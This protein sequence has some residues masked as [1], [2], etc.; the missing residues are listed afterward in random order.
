MNYISTIFK[1]FHYRHIDE[2]MVTRLYALSVKS[3]TAVIV[4][5]LLFAY[6]LYPVLSNSI[7]IWE[8]V[9]IVL[10]IVR[11]YLVYVRKHDP[12]KFPLQ[13]W[14]VLFVF[15]A[16]ATATMFALVGSFGLVYLDE[17]RRIFVVATLIGLTAGAM[18]SLFPDIRIVVGYISI[19]LIPLIVSLLFVD[20]TMHIILAFLVT[21]Y[22]VTQI[23]IILNT[24][25]QNSD[26]DK[27][28]EEIH[29]EQIKLLKKEEALDYF[30]EQA[31]IGIFSYDLQLNVT[32]S[33]EAFL[34]LFGLEKVELIGN[35]LQ[36]L[37]DQRPVNALTQALISPQIYSGPYTSVK[38]LDLWVEAQCFPVHNE[39][40]DVVGGICLIENK[41]KE[42]QA[43]ED[44]QH[45][46][47]HD[48]LTS[49]L[50][51]RGLKEFVN[52]FMTKEE[53]G[54]M[55]SLLVYL[56]L[57]KFKNINDS[58][59]HKAGDKLL[60]SI[61]S[62]LK[63]FTKETCLVSRFGGD[64]FI[65]VSPFVAQSREKA[66][67]ESKAC[68]ERIQKAFMDSFD[69]DDMKLSIKTSIGIV[70]IEPGTMNI[71]EI[72]RYADI[73]MY[74][75][76]RDCINF[77]SYY[78][79][80]LDKER[81]KIF[82]LQHDLRHASH[83][84][85]LEVY[86]QPL[87][88][89]DKNALYAAESLLRWNH[90]KLGF[91]SP[92]EFIPL[93]IETGL[94]SEI[95]WWLVEEVCKYISEMKRKGLW[96]LNYISINVNA[97]QLLLNHFV[98]EFL[99]MLSMYGL[100]NSDI[101]IEITERSIIDNFE[102]TQ[103]VI[104]VLRKEG[105]KCAIDDFGIGYSSLSYLKKLSFDT[106]KIDIAFIKNIE[107]SVDDMALLKTIL[108]IGKQFNYHIVVEGIEEEIQQKLLLEIDKD[109]VYQGFLF[110]KPIPMDT[111]TERYL[112]NKKRD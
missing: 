73:A 100:D 19:I 76:K 33:N 32:D 63:I 11:V 111:F 34:K 86:L 39:Q 75:A 57:N 10:S 4:F 89:I 92:V 41:T 43:Q 15:S 60:I 49:L 99:G 20:D 37:P 106:L 26:L 101:M 68:I 51:R 102:D 58:L 95:T 24:F 97:K 62:R 53:H 9:L 67:E 104:D 35:N 31:P 52:D 45:L 103:D 69:I 36:K 50:N 98:D 112:E 107:K 16:F 91:L 88:K 22:F 66:E 105:I 80:N 47:L 48:P 90:P 82:T 12:Q 85:E 65:V 18:S 21:V 30:F 56:D 54:T 61:A 64:E 8:G 108:E 6:T 40:E 79:T 42:H 71:D 13:T 72:I 46:A 7:L 5:S 96:K 1:M 78:D 44:L 87:V 17:V 70:I 2:S 27:R 29:K 94:I 55:Y 93:A 84:G 110:S 14:Y 77:I 74:Q 38:G 28:K 81:K 83:N 59:G 23:I 3:I 109:L 25:R